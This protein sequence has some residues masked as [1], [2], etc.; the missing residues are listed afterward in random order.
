MAIRYGRRRCSK[1]SIAA[2][3]SASRRVSTITTAPMAPLTSSSHMNQKRVCPGVPNRYRIRSRSIEMRPKSI[4]TVVVV[5]PG[6]C[7]LSSTPTPA[8]VMIASVVSGVISETEPTSVVLPTPKPP[9]MTIFADVTRPDG[10]R[11]MSKP[12]KS[13]EHPFQQ[14]RTDRVVA[15]AIEG[16]WFV[17]GD[18]A[19][20]RHI[21]DDHP[22]DTERQ[23][24][25]CGYLGERLEPPI[26]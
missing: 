2:K 8:D 1:K 9:A 5:L 18:K 26:A 25:S 16:R 3:Q 15:V 6:T 19:L 12:P 24:H 4:A 11:A 21:G 20:R 23:L 17:D 22:G 7:R 10:L 13:T 14:F